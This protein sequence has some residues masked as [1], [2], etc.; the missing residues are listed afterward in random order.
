MTLPNIY[1]EEKK[2]H[3]KS[4]NDFLEFLFYN[5]SSFLSIDYMYIAY[6]SQVGAT[7]TLVLLN[8]TTPRLMLH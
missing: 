7:L 5:L 3:Q 6:Y 8:L 2:T 1:F 4:K